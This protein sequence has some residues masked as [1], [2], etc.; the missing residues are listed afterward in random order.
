M[1]S[2]NPGW[3][4]VSFGKQIVITTR[5]RPGLIGYVS[6]T[7]TP[8]EL[9]ANVKLGNTA[10]VTGALA[11]TPSESFYGRETLLLVLFQQTTGALSGSKLTCVPTTHLVGPI[12]QIVN[13]TD[14][15][16]VHI[17]KVIVLV[18]DQT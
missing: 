13:T 17:R 14:G 3:L 10:R 16:R 15:V 8:S 6:S 5:V 2:S 11:I 7:Q 1:R 9:A 12:G 4:V 18:K